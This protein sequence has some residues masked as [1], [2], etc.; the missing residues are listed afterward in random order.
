MA[1]KASPEESQAARELEEALAKEGVDLTAQSTETPAAG[2]A[3]LAMNTQGDEPPVKRGPG[4][5]PKSAGTAKDADALLFGAIDGKGKP[6]DAKGKP[7]RPKGTGGKKA[8][9]PVGLAKQLVGIHQLAAMFTGMGELQL[10]QEEAQGLADAV[11]NVCA[12]YDLNIDGK[13]GAA[14][15]LFAACAM[16]YAPRVLQIKFRLAQ[17][18]AAYEQANPQQPSGQFAQH[19]AG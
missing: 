12:E 16:I 18:R 11:V 6:E 5:P 13:T 2:P 4:R 3:P 14:V 1:R 19:P 8:M 9:D 7:G 15:Q 10:Q 17:E